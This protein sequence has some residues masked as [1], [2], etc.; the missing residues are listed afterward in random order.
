MISASIV[1]INLST[2]EYSMG[3]KT[4]SRCLIHKFLQRGE[5]LL[6]L[7]DDQLKGDHDLG[8]RRLQLKRPRLRIGDVGE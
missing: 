4:Q 2:D 5:G 1:S 7:L 6:A 3:L 8:D